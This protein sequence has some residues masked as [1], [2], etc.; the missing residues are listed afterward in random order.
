MSSLWVI[1]F[2]EFVNFLS[3]KII[4]EDTNKYVQFV[5]LQFGTELRQCLSMEPSLAASTSQMPMLTDA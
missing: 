2:S 4:F 5:V 3:L 1:V